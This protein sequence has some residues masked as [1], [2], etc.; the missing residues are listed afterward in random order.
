ML[1]DK[2]WDFC[3][4][5]IS[6]SNLNYANLNWAVSADAE[7]KIEGSNHLFALYILWSESKFLRK[8]SL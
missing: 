7:K 5:A 4:F 8:E 1:Y 3:S 6:D 2:L